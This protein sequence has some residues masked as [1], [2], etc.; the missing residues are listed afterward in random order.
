MYMHTYMHGYVQVALLCHLF[1]PCSNIM[2]SLDSYRMIRFKH[3][4]IIFATAKGK[5]LQFIKIYK[6][7]IQNM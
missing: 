4:K 3:F 5:T 6:R 7:R 1:F 2:H